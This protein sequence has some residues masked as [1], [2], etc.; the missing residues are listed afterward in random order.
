MGRCLRRRFRK[1][2]AGARYFERE[3]LH[4]D[5]CHTVAH[6]CQP[7]LFLWRRFSTHVSLVCNG[8]RRVCKIL[9]RVA[10]H[11][12]SCLSQTYDPFNV[13]PGFQGIAPH[14][15]EVLTPY[16]LCQSKNDSLS[17]FAVQRF[18]ESVPPSSPLFSRL[19]T[20]RTMQN[21]VFRA[22]SLPAL[23]R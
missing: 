4:K 7:L 14:A 15:R 8:K 3:A 13:P 6:I 11:S 9:S 22:V 23:R 16:P 21:T 5:L 18:F 19:R 10:G 1:Q 20:D 12:E 2:C 17:I